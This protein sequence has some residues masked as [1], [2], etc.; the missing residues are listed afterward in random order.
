M[1]N[2]IVILILLSQV[3]CSQRYFDVYSQSKKSD[4]HTID[5][6]YYELET[7][8]KYKFKQHKG[9]DSFVGEISNGKTT[10]LFDYGWY[11]NGNPVTPK[12]Y[13]ENNVYGFYFD[14]LIDSLKVII[15][16]DSLENEVRENLFIETVS[17]INNGQYVANM[18]LNGERIQFSY[19]SYDPDLQ[20]K[21]NKYKFEFKEDEKYYKKLYYP[22]L[23]EKENRAGIYIEDLMSKK[24]SEYGYNK[25]AFYTYDMTESNTEEIIQILRSV[26]MKK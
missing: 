12:E 3:G 14:D 19:F 16:S 18:E 17:P 7:P 25:L 13:F 11:S 1:K 10:F 15:K 24:E 9:I 23:I 8:K 2:Q 26:R 4:W 21:F 6:K 22:K 5:L 20:T